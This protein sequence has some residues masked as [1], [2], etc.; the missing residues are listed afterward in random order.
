MWAVVR[1]KDAVVEIILD[2]A[3]CMGSR[4]PVGFQPAPAAR[5][6][7]MWAVVRLKDVVVGFI[8]DRAACMGCRVQVGF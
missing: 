5:A 4:V 6:R 2:R 8:L 7:R 1:L 3:A